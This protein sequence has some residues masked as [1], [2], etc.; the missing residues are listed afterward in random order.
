MANTQTVYFVG[1]LAG[2]AKSTFILP[3]MIDAKGGNLV[4]LSVDA[5]RPIISHILTGEVFRIGEISIQGRVEFTQDIHKT[6]ELDIMSTEA[7]PKGEDYYA[8]FG[9]V[10]FVKYNL[11]QGLDII[12]EGTAVRPKVVCDFENDLNRI[13][14]D[15]KAAFIG[16]GMIARSN[17]ASRPNYNPYG[18]DVVDKNEKLKEETTLVNRPNFRHFDVIDY[19]SPTR[20]KKDIILTDDDFEAT[21]AEVIKHLQTD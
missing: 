11:V 4:S 12:I 3:G 6:K 21:A 14:V 5:I 16:C 19:L 10:G 13:G 9:A 7:D 18:P 2:M 20:L 17:R 8:W 1:G 15:V